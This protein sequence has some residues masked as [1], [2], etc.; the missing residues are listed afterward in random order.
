MPLR[1]SNRSSAR[2]KSAHLSA[3]KSANSGRSSNWS[4]KRARF[5]S[6]RRKDAESSA[7]GSVSLSPNAPL[8]PPWRGMGKLVLL[9][10]WEGLGVG[11]GPE[12]VG[13]ERDFALGS[14]SELS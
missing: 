12:R 7:D 6:R 1:S 11:L 10:S 13:P 9:P 8:S 14:S 3:Q 2:N 5:C 4:T